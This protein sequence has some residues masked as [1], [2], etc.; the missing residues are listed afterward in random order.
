VNLCTKI[1]SIS[2]ACFIRMLT[3]TLFTDG[4]IRTRSSWFRDTVNGLR[5]SSGDVLASISG[6]LCLSLACDAKLERERAAV[7]VLRTQERYGLSDWDWRGV[8]GALWWLCLLDIPLRANGSDLAIAFGSCSL[9]NV[10]GRLSSQ[11]VKGL[12]SWVKLL[13]LRLL[14]TICSPDTADV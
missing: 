14:A 11:I 1:C 13:E 10:I 12:W 5:M 8:S 2:S 9:R 3:R 6:T 7:R 4:S